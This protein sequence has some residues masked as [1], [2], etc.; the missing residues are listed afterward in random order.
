MV[1]KRTDSRIDG[2]KT[3]KK[4][5]F[6]LLPPHRRALKPTAEWP[7]ADPLGMD[8][9]DLGEEIFDYMTCTCGIE[10]LN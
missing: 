8:I 5:T 6:D 9:F 1:C 3:G 2:I 7:L 10:P 4:G